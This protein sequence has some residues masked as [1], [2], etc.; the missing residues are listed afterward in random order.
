MAFT[1]IPVAGGIPEGGFGSNGNR[2]FAADD[3]LIVKLISIF[4]YLGIWLPI[5]WVRLSVIFAMIGAAE[6]VL[7]NATQEKSN[8]KATE[9]LNF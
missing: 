2:V 5:Y 3:P 9:S 6:M 1:V 4:S 7:G 8:I